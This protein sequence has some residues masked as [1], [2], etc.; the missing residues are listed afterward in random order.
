MYR[1]PGNLK[2]YEQQNLILSII[3]LFAIKRTLDYF[4]EIYTLFTCNITVHIYIFLITCLLLS[5]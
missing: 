3:E 4:D 5:G 1:L 2:L